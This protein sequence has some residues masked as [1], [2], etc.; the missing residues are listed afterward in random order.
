MSIIKKEN[1]S[2]GLPIGNMNGGGIDSLQVPLS[3][4]ILPCV[5][6]TRPKPTNQPKKKK[7]KQKPDQDSLL[8]DTFL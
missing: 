8:C 1:A 6:L 2:T 4:T 7:K 3:K 5:K